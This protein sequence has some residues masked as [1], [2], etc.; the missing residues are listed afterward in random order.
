M[1][2]VR[3]GRRMREVLCMPSCGAHAGGLRSVRQG[4]SDFGYARSPR[5][6][7]VRA[8]TSLIALTES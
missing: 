4:W 5:S 3:G 7:S 8:D 6:R 2:A 1:A